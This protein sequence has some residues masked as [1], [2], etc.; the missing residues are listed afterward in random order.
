MPYPAYE[1]YRPYEEDKFKTST[2]KKAEEALAEARPERAREALELDFEELREIFGEDFLGIEEAERFAGRPFTQEERQEVFDLWEEK[3]REQN[4]TRE[5]LERLKQE[6]FMVMVRTPTMMLEDKEVSVTIENLRKKHPDL[7]WKEQDWY[8]KEDFATKDGV[9]RKI[10]I[11]KKEILE[12]SRSQ[13]WDQ[14]TE[15]LKQWAEDH[16]IALSD[17][18]TLRRTPAEIAH[19]IL[20]FHSARQQRILEKDWDW[21]GVQSSDGNF[22]YV[23]YF[24]QDG[25]GVKYDHREYSYPY[26]GV[27]PAR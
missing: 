5:E 11:V 27:C 3:V 17:P 6:G 14:Q 26:L 20:A 25:L 1:L 19:D 7:F 24:G 21:T 18:N 12:E 23:G 15:I 2:Q 4:L 8:N 13:N 10:G 22:V 9:A 16:G